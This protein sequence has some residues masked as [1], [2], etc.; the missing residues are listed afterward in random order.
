MRVNSKLN[1]RFELSLDTRQAAAIVAASL[2]I[3]AGAFVLGMSYGTRASLSASPATPKDSLATLDEPLTAAP[4]EDDALRAHE[5]LTA[6]RPEALPA[7]GVKPVAAVLPARPERSEAKSKGEAGDSAPTLGR[8]EREQGPTLSRHTGEGDTSATSAS[9]P[10]APSPSKPTSTSTSPISRS[11]SALAATPTT[12][13]PPS[14]SALPS[15]TGN[16][17]RK[18]KHDRVSASRRGAYT[19]QV[20]SVSQRADAERVAKRFARRS[21]RIVAAD[22]PGK[23]RV[24]RVQVGSY[25]TRDAASHGLAAIGGAGF[26]T[27]AR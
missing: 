24:W 5:A 10:S 17:E 1:E 27:A 8:D 19:I 22:V 11:S 25:A 26:V 6:A 7:P 13:D 12:I 16:P 23:G 14:H 2:I 9:N 18:P 3:V 4:K 15:R 20:A 21:S